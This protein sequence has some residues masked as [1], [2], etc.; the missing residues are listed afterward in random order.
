MSEVQDWFSLLFR[1]LHL[2]VGAAWIGTSFYFNWLNHALRTAENSQDREK[3]VSGEL[4]AVHGGGFYHVQKYGVSPEKLPQT[5]HWFKWEAYMTLITGLCL[6]IIT[7]YLGSIQLTAYQDGQAVLTYTQSV[8]IGISTL[9]IGWIFYHLL[10][11]SPLKKHNTLLFI[12]ILGFIIGVSWFLSIVF[13]GRAAFM[14]VGAM[15]GTIM[16]LN[17]FFV[18]IPGQKL[19]VE[20]VKKGEE[21]DPQA[22]KAGA[23]RSLHNN[24]FTLP[25]LFVMVSNHY[26]HTYGHQWNWLI[27]LGLMMISVGAKHYFNLKNQGTHQIWILPAAA[28][29]MMALAFVSHSTSKKVNWSIQSNSHSSS[30]PQNGGSQLSAQALKGKDIFLNTAQPPCG[31]CHTLKEAKTQ[32]TVGPVLD[33]LKPTHQQILLVVKNGR[34]AMPPQPHL[35]AQEI[36][37]LAHYVYEATR[38][39]S[40]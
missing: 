23:Q 17:V 20:A 30:L 21:P 26:P 35:S 4:W 7:Y 39:S 22:G 13:N 24:Y 33:L 16:A 12:I 5:L 32:G 34:G 37:D 28:L 10:C 8:I 38:L 40:P 3:G 25:V 11:N 27:L 2:I 14:H 36:E 31:L 9:S 15:M 19:M 18:I 1:W 6:L 29:A